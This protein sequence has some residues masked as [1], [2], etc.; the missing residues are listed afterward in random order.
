ML[1]PSPFSVTTNTPGL[2]T[3]QLQFRLN[4]KSEVGNPASSVVPVMYAS[5]RE[6]TAMATPAVEGNGAS[7]ALEGAL[8]RNVAYLIPVP[9]AFTSTTNALKLKAAALAEDT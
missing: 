9:A 2:P 3:L 4:A 6:S 5:P 8:S 7:D 1:L